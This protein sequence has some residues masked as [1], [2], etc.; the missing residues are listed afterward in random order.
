MRAVARRHNVGLATV[1]RWVARAGDDP[2]E[3]VDWADRSS[4]P[5]RQPH[6]TPAGIEDGILDVR[7]VLR[8]ESVLGEYGAA[9]IRREL[10]A[11]DGGVGAVP[12]VRTIGR[13]LERRGALDA[14][15][16]IRRRAPPPGWYLP[17]LAAR[18]V[19]LDSFDVIDGLR[20]KGGRHLQVLTGISLH[21]GLAEAWPGPVV[22]TSSAM[23]ALEAHWR[24]HGLPAYAQFDND[25]RFQGSHG[26][27][28]LIGRLVRLLLGLSV[29]PVFAPP[30]EPGFQ[31]AIESLNGR[32][33]AKVWGRFWSPELVDLEARSAAWIAAT[34]ARSAMRIEAAPPRLPFPADWRSDPATPP[35]GRIVFLRRTSVRG[36]VEILGRRFQV[37]PRW[38]HRLVRAEADLTAGRLR[39]YALRRREPADQPLL[40]DLPYELAMRRIWRS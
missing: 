21:G 7:R 14:R 37:D 40:C 39:C 27:V 22:T 2:L 18:Q 28:D 33:Q 15:R 32:W 23:A 34:R 5:A 24:R 16:R 12:S 8:A 30:R 4:A 26:Y 38:A 1:Q 35:A 25:V 6:R 36:D 19:E 29:V 31:A 13:V 20:L 3:L 17:D 11:R 9:A 10:L